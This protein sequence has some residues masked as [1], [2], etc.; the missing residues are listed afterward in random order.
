[1]AMDHQRIYYLLEKELQDQLTAAEAEELMDLKLQEEDA[2]LVAAIAWFMEKEAAWPVYRTAE[3]EA[4]AFKNI[5]SVDTSRP[6]DQQQAPTRVH[7][8]RRW[9]WAAAVFALLVTGVLF[10]YLPRK[11]AVRPDTTQVLPGAHI[12]AA[13]EGAVLQLADGRQVVLD[14]LTEGEVA[15]QNGSRVELKNGQLVYSATGQAAG[16]LS[17]NTMI[18]PKGRQFHMLLPDGSKVWLNAA[19]SITYP[20]YFTGAER[21]VTISGEAYF[22]I[23][24]HKTLPFRV[25]VNEQ[26]EIS[27]LATSFN[28]NAYPEEKNIEATL[29][30]GSVRVSKPDAAA[31]SVQLN[32]GQQ[33]RIVAGAAGGKIAVLDN[34]DLDIVMAWRNGLF[35]FEDAGLDEAMRQ[36]GR[37]YDV[38][39]VYEGEIPTIEFGGK[40]SRNKTLAG[41]IQALTEAGLQCRL[42]GRKLIVKK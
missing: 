1:M 19:S 8:W 22:E 21:L 13:Q 9:G 40:L 20:T 23:V 33:A 25:R 24:Q 28:V 35:N 6:A 39:I 18:T 41:V 16:A 17:Y 29:L 4:T 2:E 11:Q 3:Q 37:W 38:E 27:V 32:P 14:S 15:V 42:E 12:P 34:V 5:L 26:A 10:L 36:V 30:E 7:L 31:G